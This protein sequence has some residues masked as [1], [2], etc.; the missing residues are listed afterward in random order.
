MNVLISGK[1]K[2]Q[3]LPKISSKWNCNFCPYKEDKEFVVQG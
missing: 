2:E 3:R 1:I